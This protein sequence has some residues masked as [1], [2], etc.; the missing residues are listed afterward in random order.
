MTAPLLGSLRPPARLL[1]VLLLIICCYAAL[2]LAGI[3]LAMPLFG[4]SLMDTVDLLNN[5][6]DPKVVPLLMFLQV[7][8]SVGIFLMPP[9]LAGLLFEGNTFRYLRLDR[10]AGVHFYLYTLLILVVSTPLLQALITLNEQ[11]DLPAFMQE[12]ESWMKNSEEQA[13]RLT[14]AFL[15]GT[16]WN[17]LLV[18]LLVVAVLPG[19]GEELMFR[20]LLQRLLAEWFRNIHVAIWVA[21]LLFG[22]MHLQFYGLL[23]RLL[24]GALLGYLFYWSGSLW[25]PV[26]AHFLNNAFTVVMSWMANRNLI[27]PEWEELGST[28]NFYVLL[29][30][31][32][33]MAGLIF[34][35]YRKRVLPAKINDL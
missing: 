9:L 13:T 28:G 26:F 8:Q 23:P 25:I 27:G 24:L 1:F 11:M 15:Q 22:A 33:L 6:E 18:N 16:S 5:L 2:S 14:E 32:I 31:T 7:V 17:A 12:V 35:F 20:G 34:L 10:P 19:I 30:S 3:L 21:A 4:I 29:G